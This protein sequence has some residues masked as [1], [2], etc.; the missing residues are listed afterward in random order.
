MRIKGKLQYHKQRDC[1]VGHVDAHLEQGEQG[2]S[3]IVLANSLLCFVI[4]GLTTP[5]RIPAAYYFTKG[6]AGYQLHELIIFV[7][8]KVEACGF[9]IVW[10]VADNHKLNVNAMKLLRN[11]ILTYRT[12]HPCDP[13]RILFMTFDACLCSKMFGHSFWHMTLAQN[14]Q[15]LL[16]TLRTCTSCRKA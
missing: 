15:F 14:L 3:N 13:E 6:L 7:I 5:F 16:H 1:F 8:K 10:L 12:E 2:N 4:S 11:G 9:R